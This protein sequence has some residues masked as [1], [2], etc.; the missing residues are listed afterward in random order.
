MRSGKWAE[1]FSRKGG[2]I[3]RNKCSYIFLCSG[4]I[5]AYFYHLLNLSQNMMDTHTALVPC[6]FSYYL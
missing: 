1:F 3:F 6:G 4:T 5:Y 2:L